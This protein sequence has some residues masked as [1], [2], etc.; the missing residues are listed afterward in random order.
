MRPGR[1]KI[2]GAGE[3]WR[4]RGREQSREAKIPRKRRLLIPMGALSRFEWDLGPD[5]P[6]PRVHAQAFTEGYE[7]LQVP[8][9]QLTSHI[10]FPASSRR[11]SSGGVGFKA[12]FG[13]WKAGGKVLPGT[14]KPQRICASW[15]PVCD[16]G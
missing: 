16:R 6:I 3:E 12:L 5:L 2:C 9:S 1:L 14:D 15:V 8:D 7:G 11:S 13:T 4:G 10:P